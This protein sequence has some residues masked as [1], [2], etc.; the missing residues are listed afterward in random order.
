[1]LYCNKSHERILAHK[2]FCLFLGQ[3]EC[4]YRMIATSI[5]QNL[6]N[7]GWPS[8]ANEEI[9]CTWDIVGQEG[10]RVEINFEKFNL[11]NDEVLVN[12]IL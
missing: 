8:A 5:P 9:M 10:Y 12:E 4:G 7:P 6:T 1:M 3:L 2:I 11:K